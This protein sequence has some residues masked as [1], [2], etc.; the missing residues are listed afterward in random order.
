MLCHALTLRPRASRRPLEWPNVDVRTVFHPPGSGKLD[1]AKR[2]LHVAPARHTAGVA[3]CFGL[4][5]VATIVGF[6]IPQ[7]VKANLDPTLDKLEAWLTPPPR[8]P[9][10]PMPPPKPSPPPYHTPPPSSPPKPAKPPPMPPS[11]PLPPW[12]TPP[13]Q[14][15]S[16][17]RPPR[18]PPKPPLPPGVSNPPPKPPGPP[19]PPHH[20]PPPPSPPLPPY[21]TPPPYPPPKPPRP[22]FPERYSWQNTSLGYDRHLIL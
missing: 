6:T 11:P 17:P 1:K 19:K 10:P 5:I 14:P 9:F 2:V 3:L 8:P 7:S 15:P 12:T 13:P 20:P 22:L 21:R 18:P 4:M 16:P